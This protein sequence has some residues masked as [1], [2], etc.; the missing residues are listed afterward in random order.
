MNLWVLN[1][2]LWAYK[3]VGLTLNCALQALFYVMC[4]PVGHYGLQA[5]AGC[6]YCEPMQS[7]GLYEF[8]Y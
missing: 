1:D 3:Y 8:L 5:I 6:S 2:F 4:R 7:V